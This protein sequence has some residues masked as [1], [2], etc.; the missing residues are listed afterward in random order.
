MFTLTNLQY[1][2]QYLIL[3]PFIAGIFALLWIFWN[4]LQQGKH[5]K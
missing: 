3:L 5:R 2:L 1:D 4:L